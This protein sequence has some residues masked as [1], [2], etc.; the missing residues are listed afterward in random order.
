MIA[1]V[2]KV[3]LGTFTRGLVL[4][5]AVMLMSGG[6]LLTAYLVINK[7]RA[8]KAPVTMEET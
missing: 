2:A 3:M 5:T 7:L 4:R 8:K 1:S 6:L